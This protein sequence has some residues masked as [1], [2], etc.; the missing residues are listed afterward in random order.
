MYSNK[1]KTIDIRLCKI[2]LKYLRE[3]FTCVTTKNNKK[4]KT[5][6]TSE[7]MDN[8]INTNKMKRRNSKN[9]TTLQ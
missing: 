3:K 4:M 2:Q 8:K 7:E 5:K 9:K 1:M 6:N